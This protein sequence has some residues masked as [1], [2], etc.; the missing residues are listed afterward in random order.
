MIVSPAEISHR[1][2]ASDRPIRPWKAKF[3][4]RGGDEGRAG[5]R[6]ALLGYRNGRERR[7]PVVVLGFEDLQV[8]EYG[9]RILRVH[10]R[11]A[12]GHVVDELL[13]DVP[14][15]AHAA[16]ILDLHPL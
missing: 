1:Y 8:A 12:G 6:V 14:E 7:V 5:P 3:S 13:V 11:P 15:Y 4:M 16:G 9:D 10:H 2:I